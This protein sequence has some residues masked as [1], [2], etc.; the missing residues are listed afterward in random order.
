MSILKM[1]MMSRVKSQPL[2]FLLNVG[3]HC[4]LGASSYRPPLPISS[5]SLSSSLSSNNYHHNH[6]F[7]LYYYTQQQRRQRLF[8]HSL[9]EMPPLPI[10]QEEEEGQ[11]HNHQDYRRRHSQQQQQQ[12]QQRNTNNNKNI[13]QPKNDIYIL[14]LEQ[15][16]VYI[17]K[18]SQVGRRFKEH[19]CGRGCAWTRLYK[20]LRLLPRLGNVQGDGD[21]AERDEMLRYAYYRGVQYTRGWKFCN[22]VLTEEDY[23]EIEMNIREVFDLCRRCGRPGHFVSTCRNTR[24][25][26]G[27][28]CD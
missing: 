5:S 16:R 8:H 7:P 19:K 12:Q 15:G 18:S 27:N 9:I 2:L 25:R 26:L 23:R 10:L 1:A 17:G 28:L 11:H 3:Q 21:A 24:D 22:P 20:P 4:V 13:K 6:H 14:E